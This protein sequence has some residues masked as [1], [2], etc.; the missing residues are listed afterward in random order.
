[1]MTCSLQEKTKWTV[2]HF[3]VVHALGRNNVVQQ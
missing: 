1:L 2:K 3:C